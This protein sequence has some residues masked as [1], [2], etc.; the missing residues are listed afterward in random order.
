MRHAL[1]LPGN[2]V[3]LLLFIVFALIIMCWLWVDFGCVYRRSRRVVLV[4]V[5]ALFIPYTGIKRQLVLG[6]TFSFDSLA[7]LPDTKTSS[8]R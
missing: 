2:V 7:T 6:S 8:E 1:H 4:P 5:I 3:G